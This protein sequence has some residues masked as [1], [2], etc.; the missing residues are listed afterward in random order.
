MTRRCPTCFNELENNEWCSV[1]RIRLHADM[2]K[3]VDTLDLGSSSARSG[4]SSP[5]IRT[6]LKSH[7][8]LNE[9]SGYGN[10][11]IPGVCLASA[12]HRLFDKDYNNV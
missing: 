11:I 2:V 6:N 3:L 5:S 8:F 12:T 10:Y 7:S 9:W 1:C 4:G